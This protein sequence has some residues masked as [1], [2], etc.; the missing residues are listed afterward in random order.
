[1]HV[2][3]DGNSRRDNTL[4]I[5]GLLTL[6]E[7]LSCR[8]CV[9]SVQ[10]YEFY[11]AMRNAVLALNVTPKRSFIAWSFRETHASQV[12]RR[13]TATPDFF[14]S[15]EFNQPHGSH[16]SLDSKQY[17]VSVLFECVI[18]FLY[19]NETIDPPDMNYLAFSVGIICLQVRVFHIICRIL[20][21]LSNLRIIFISGVRSITYPSRG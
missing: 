2:S 16:H 13:T 7:S 17:F 10:Y 14:I 5:Y 20:F 11:Y 4:V 9:H 3:I 15:R 19:V 21:K 8:F 6:V 18:F 1:M 12:R